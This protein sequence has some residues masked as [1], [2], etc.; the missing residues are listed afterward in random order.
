MR[1]YNAQHPFDC[2]LDLHAR[3]MSVCILNHAGESLVHRHMQ[4]GPAPFL[5]TMASSREA[6]VVCV[7][8]LCTWY[9]LADLGAHEGIP[10]VLGHALSLQ[11]I[12]GGKAQNA[13]IDAPQS[14]VLLRG[15]RLPQ[16][17]VSPADRRA[18]RNLLRRRMSLR[19]RRAAWLTHIHHPTSQSNLPEMGQTIADQANR[20]GVAERFPDPAGPQSLA[21][22]RERI[23]HYDPLR[24]VP[25]SGPCSK[26]RSRTM[27]PRSLCCARSQGSARA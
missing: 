7:A 4:A 22:A 21:V 10:C 8:C 19:R 24:Y 13:K 18:P 16:A 6:L 25:W 5:K 27:P 2:G 14:A 20:E 15:G 17:S 3:T 23:G 26:R 12:H 11:A 1:F 9:G